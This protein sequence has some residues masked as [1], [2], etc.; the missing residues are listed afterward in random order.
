MNK[1]LKTGITIGVSAIIIAAL[2]YFFLSRQNHVTQPPFIGTSSS[3]TRP[4]DPLPSPE[5]LKAHPDALA[6]AER[7]CDAGEG[8]ETVALCDVVHSAKASLM[9]DKFHQGAGGGPK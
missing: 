9:A 4:N 2:A 1:S 8:Q 7:R 6:D 3:D 5:F